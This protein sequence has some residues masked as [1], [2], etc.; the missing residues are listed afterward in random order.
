VRLRSGK[1]TEKR[2]IE[3]EEV[4]RWLL[5]AAALLVRAARSLFVQGE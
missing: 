1:R 2:L 5:V 3:E 4:G